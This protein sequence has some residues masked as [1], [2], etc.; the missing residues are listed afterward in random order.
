MAKEEKTIEKISLLGYYPIETAEEVIDADKDV[1]RK[2]AFKETYK[3]IMKIIP[4]YFISM[5]KRRKTGTSSSG[6]F[7]QSII[8]TQENAKIETKEETKKE[9]QKQEK[10]RAD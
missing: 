8:V 4:D 10:E 5:Q 1:E 3:R 6:G 2:E 7:T 9:V